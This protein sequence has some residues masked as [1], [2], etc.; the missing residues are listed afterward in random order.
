MDKE[1]ILK[2][3]K[4]QEKTAENTIR[5]FFMTFVTVL[6]LISNIPVNNLAAVENKTLSYKNEEY[7]VILTYDENAE[8]P[9]GSVLKVEEIDSE[10]D[11]YN[12]YST[13]TKDLLKWE[14]EDFKLCSFLQITIL[15][16]AGNVVIPQDK[17][18]IKLVLPEEEDD[19]EKELVIDSSNVIALN[20]DSTLINGYTADTIVSDDDDISLEFVKDSEEETSFP[21]VVLAQT[22]KE[23]VIKA[24]DDNSYIVQAVYDADSGIPLGAEMVVSEI[25]EDD[26]D[27]D[28]YVEK[29]VDK[30]CGS[31]DNV[32]L[33]KA[34]DISFIDPV[35]KNEYQPSGDVSI[36]IRL[37]NEDF[38]QYENLDVV[39]IHGE[40]NEQIDVVKSDIEED[41][42]NF[43]TDGLS[44]F[45]VFAYTTTSET[46][47]YAINLEDRTSINLSELIEE[48]NITEFTISG[49][50]D[51]SSNNEKLTVVA[52][53]EGGDW[54]ISV[55]E[56]FS[57]GTLTITLTNSSQVQI[58]V[59]NKKV[60]PVVTPPEGLDLV[61]NGDDQ[62]LINPGSASGGTMMYSLK[63]DEDYSTEIP[64]AKATGNYTVYYKIE[65]DDDYES[66][67]GSVDSVIRKRP[68]TVTAEDKTK[69][70]NS[71]DDPELSVEITGLM[72]GD[73]IV[74]DVSRVEGEDVGTYAIT[75]IGEADQGN[76]LVTFVPGSFTITAVPVTLTANSGW[77]NYDGSE[78]VLSGF[79]SSVEGLSFPNVSAE[80]RGT[81]IG[82]YDVTF[83]DVI[84]DETTDST[85]N[86]VVHETIDGELKI[87]NILSK[88][89]IDLDGNWATWLIRVNQNSLTLNNGNRITLKDTFTT[90]QSI[91]YS[92]VQVSSGVTYDY[93]GQTGT[94]SIPDETSVTISYRTRVKTVG[95]SV[96]VVDFGNTAL[97]EASGTEIDSVTT[98]ES[99]SIYPSASDVAGNTGKYMVKLYVYGDANMQA[100][101]SGAQFI[102]LDSNKRPMTFKKG[103]NAGQGVTFTTNANGWVDIELDEEEGDVS[104]EKN[105]SYSLEMIKAPDGYKLDSTLYNFMITDDPNYNSG[106]VWTYFNG[107]TI[108]VRLYAEEAGL[109][110]SLRFSGNYELSTYQQNKIVVSLERKNGSLWEQI[111]QHSYSEFVSGSITFNYGSAENPFELNETY[112]V[113]ET[114]EKPWDLSDDVIVTTTYYLIIGSEESENSRTPKEFLVDDVG[115]CINVVI[116]NEYEEPKLTITKMNKITGETLSGAVFTVKTAKDDAVVTSYTTGDD[117]LVVINSGSPYSSEILYY[118]EETAAPEHYLLPKNSIKTY[119]YFCNEPVLIP[120]ILAD[121]PEG[122][123]AVNLTEDFESLSLDNQKESLSIPVMVTWQGNRWPDNVDRV[124]I[125][126]YQSVNKTEPTPVY[127]GQGDPMKVFLT[128]TAA[129]NDSAF[130]N[131]PTRDA[132]NN[133]ITYSIKEEH[134]YK[135]DDTD[136]I[137]DYVQEYGVSD[138]GVYIVRNMQATSLTVNKYWYDYDGQPV[139][140]ES[141]LN[142]QSEVIFDVYRSTTMIPEEIREGNITHDE[143]ANFVSGLRKVRS[144]LTFGKAQNWTLTIN[145][146]EKKDNSDNPYYYYVFEN[147]PSFGDEIYVP[148]EAN[149]EISIRNTIAPE[150]VKLTVSK[151]VV[152]DPRPTAHET[153]FTFT[154]L[155]KKSENPIRNYEVSDSLTTDWNGEV[156]FKLKHD[157]SI[158]LTLPAGVTA[159]LTEAF[160]P[161]F[162]VTTE[163]VTPDLDTDNDRIFSY[164]TTAGT[165][166]NVE[167]TNTLKVICKVEYGTESV[168]VFESLKSA[169][170]FIRVNHDF[171]LD[172]ATIQM[173]EDYN[174]PSTDI[175]DVQAG[176]IITLTTA[177]TDAESFPFVTDRTENVD[178]AIITRDYSGGSLFTNAGDLTLEKVWLDGNKDFCS[179]NTDGGLINNTGTL[180][181]NSGVTL[182]NSKS[183]GKGGAIYSSG[184]LNMV[185]NTAV[186]NN[187]ASNASAIYLAA[188]TLNISGGTISNNNGAS[189]GAVVVEDASCHINLYGSPVIFNNTNTSSSAA[190]IYLGADSDNVINVISPGLEADA[191]IGVWGME[192]HREIGEQFASSEY[193]VTANLNR[194]VNDQYDYRGKL[195]EG[196]STNIIW[197]GLSLTISKVAD[198]VGSNPNDSFTITLTSTSIRKS[199]Y[200]INGSYDYTVTP[201]RTNRPGTIVF[202]NVRAGNNI[203]ISPLPVGTYT[204]SETESY[205]EPKFTAENT[206]IS[207]PVEIND[208]VFALDGN[209]TLTVTNTRRLAD[210]SLTKTLTDKLLGSAESKVFNFEVKLTE[211]DGTAVANFALGE[212]ITTGTNGVASFTM[213]PLNYGSS[214]KNFVAP[215]GAK[216]EITEVADDNY[217][218]TTSAKTKQGTDITD[219]DTEHDNIF[220]FEVTDEG[221]DVSFTNVRKLVEIE[222]SK[223]L[224][225]KV[226]NTE[227]FEFTITL[228][229]EDG[230]PASNYVLYDDEDPEKRIVTGSDGKATVNFAFGPGESSKSVELSM[231]EGTKLTVAET[232]T[233]KNINGTD[234]KIYNT[235]YSVNGGTPVSGETVTIQKVKETDTSIAFKNTRKTQTITVKN[236]VS[237]Y[238]GNVVPFTFTATVDDGGNDY[239]VHD[240]V[241]G[242]QTFELA[243][244]QSKTLTVPYGSTLKV[245]ENFVVGYDTTVKLGSETAVTTLFKEFVVS[246]NDTL[247]FNNAQLIGL[248]LKNL[249]SSALTG[250]QVYVSYGTKM[251]RVN[252]DMQG[253]TQVPLNSHWAMIDI[254]AGKTAILEVNHYNSVTDAQDYTVKGSD[255]AENYYYT[256]VN[257]PSFHEYA[258][259][260]ILR[261]YGSA[262]FEVKG[263]LR[264]SVADSTVTFTEQPLVSFDVNGGVWTTEMEGY[265]DRDGDQK[266]YQKAVDKGTT[267]SAP[268]PEPAYSAEGINFLGWTTDQAYA[269]Q[270]HSDGQVDPDKLYNFNNSVNAPV[271]LFA[272]WSRGDTR[273]VTV[274]NSLAEDITVT[275]T[276]TRDGVAIP[277]YLLFI[278]E[279][280]EYRTDENGTVTFSLPKNQLQN[281]SVPESGTKLVL[282]SSEGNCIAYSSTY[283]DADTVNSSFTINPVDSDG[284]VAFIA[285]ICK[286]TDRS[287]NILYKADG[288]PAV[289]STLAAAFTDYSGVLYTDASHTTAATQAAVKMLIDEYAISSKHTFPTKDVILTTA[290]KSDTYFPYVGVNEHST[291]YRASGFNNDSLFTYSNTATSVTLT[292]IILD[293]KNVA[294]SKTANGSLIRQNKG[295]LN[296]ETGTTLR[297]VQYNDYSDG[298]NSRGGAIYVTQGTLNVNAGS[299]Y[300]LAARRGGAICAMDKAS[301]NVSGSNGSTK[302]EKCYSQNDD[303]GAIYYSNTNE[304]ASLTINGGQDDQPGII[305]T[306]CKTNFKNTANTGNGGAIYAHTNYI[307]N[308]TISGCAFTECSARTTNTASTSGYGG[309]AISALKVKTLSVSNC[310]FSSCD[311]LCGGGAIA[312]YVKTN[313]SGITISDCSF[314]NCSCKSQGG[315]LAV[316]QDDNG[317][318]TSNTKLTIINSSFNDCSSGTNNSSGGAIQCYLP[319]MDFTSTSFAGCWAGKEGGA[320]NHYFGNNYGEEWSKSS[321]TITNCEFYRCRAEDRYDT[322]ALQHYG[323]GMNTK[324][325]TVQVTGS[326][327]EDCVSTLKEGG[328]LHLGGQG[329]NSKSTIN[330]STFKNCTAKNGGGALLSSAQTLEINNSNFYGCSSSNSNGGAVYHYRNSRA[331]S[332]QNTTTITNSTFSAVPG[333]EGED[334]V[335]CNAA[336]NGGAIWTR[337]KNVTIQKCT[338]DSCSANGNG[339]AIYLSNSSSTNAF[340]TGSSTKGT[341]TNCKA[342]NGSAVYTEYATIFKD[343][344]ITENICS[345]INDGAI[346]GGT[347]YFEGKVIVKN[348]ECSEDSQYKHDVLMQNNNST[349]IYT[350][351]TAGQTPQGLDESAS[352]GV[353]V[354]DEYFNLRGTEGKAFGTWNAGADNYLDCFFND[355]DDGLFG[356]QSSS[357]D[358]NIYWGVYLCKITDAKGNTLKRANGRD[359]IYQRLTMALDDFTSVTEG[360]PV[361][362]KILIEN[363]NIQQEAQIDNFPN[364]DIT[365]TTET[366]TGTDPVEGKYDGKHPYRGKEGTVCTISRTNSN[367][368]LF[369]LSNA[370]ATFQ[371]ENISFDGR[372]DKSSTV[373]DFR[374]IEATAGSLIINGGTTFRYGHEKLYGGAIYIS[375]P[376]A[377]LKINSSKDG[378]VLFDHCVQGNGNNR[379]NGGGAIYSKSS[380]T[381][382]NTDGGKAAFADCNAVRGGAIMLGDNTSADMFLSVTGAEFINC[383]SINEGGAVYVNNNNNTGTRTTIKDSSFENCYT[384]GNEQWSYGGAVDTKTA[385][386][387]VDGCSFKGCY[388]RSNGGAVNHGLNEVNRIKTTITN[389]SFENCSTVGT[390]S[391]Y[392]LGGSVSTYAENVEVTDSTFTNSTASSNGGALYC[393]SETAGSAIISGTSFTNCASDLTNGYGGAIYAKVKTLTL[394]N[395]E[396]G[397]ATNIKNC[398]AKGYSGAVHMATNNS[399][400]NIK[401]NTLISGCYA[402]KGAVIYLINT[403]TLKLTG[404]PEFTKNGYTSSGL[405]ST[406][407]ACIYLAEGSLID[408]SDSPK[409]SRNNITNVPRVTNGGT[410]DYVRQDLY[411]AGY[412]DIKAVSIHVSGEL[413]GD[414][415]WV[416]PEQSPHR[417]PE[418]QFATTEANV[419][420][421]SLEKFRNALDDS[422]TTCSHGEYL[423]GVRIPNKDSTGTIVY[424]D[425][426]YSLSFKKIDNK[427]VAVADAYFTLF[428]DK[429]CTQVYRSAKS[430]NGETDTDPQ[431][432]ILARGVVQ[433]NSIPIGVYYMKETVVPVGYK[434][435]DVTYIVLVGSPSLEPNDYNRDLW[436]DGGPLDVDSAPTLVAK[437]TV[438]SGKYYGIFALKTDG[439]ADLSRSIA[440]ANAGIVNTRKDY[441]AY[442][443]KTD[444]EGLPLPNTAFTL[445]T[446]VRDEHG[447][448]QYYD[449]NYPVLELWSRDGE[450]YPDPAVSAD[451]T[452]KY[453]KADGGIL[454]KGLVYFR[455][456]PVGTYYLLETAYPDRNGNNR[457]TFFVES[458]RL[459]KLVVNDNIDDFVLSEWQEDGSYIEVI[460]KDGYF[461]FSNTEAVVKLTDNN[462]VLLYTLG[463]D[464]E[465]LFPAIYSSLENGIKAAQTGSLYNSNG[466]VVAD[467]THNPALKL[468]MMKDFTIKENIIYSSERDLTLTTAERTAPSDKDRYI[469]STTRTSDTSRAEVSRG[470]NENTSDN[471]NRGALITVSGNSE[472]TLQNVNFN[473]HSSDYNGR[474][475]HVTDGSLNILNSTR[476]NSFKQEAAAGST[477]EYN[478]RGGAILMD[479]GTSLYI[480]GS[481]SN[482]SAVFT[483]NQVLNNRTGVYSAADGGA[484]A[485]GDNCTVNISNAQ[486]TGNSASSAKDGSG[487]G[488]AIKLEDTTLNMTDVVMRQ[489][490]AYEGS[491]V[492]AVNNAKVYIN[493]GSI[494]GN[495]T[496]G[497]SGGAINV[498][499][500]DSRVYFSGSPYVFE[501][502]DSTGTKQKDMVLNYDTNSII[503]TASNGLTGGT[504]G[505]YVVD[506]PDGSWFKDHGQS[507][508]PFG[509]F[510]NAQKLDVFKND[511]LLELYG[512][513]NEDDT[514]DILIYWVNIGVSVAFKKIDSFGN[515]LDGATFTLYTDR[516]CTH[517]YEKDNHQ[518]AVAISADGITT[519]NSNNDLLNKGT[520][521]FEEI[522]E[523]IYYLKERRSSS[524]GSPEGYLE[525]AKTYVVLI[526]K[527]TQ[528]PADPSGTIWARGRLLENITQAD[529]NVQIEKYNSDKAYYKLT[530]DYR[531]AIFL[532]DENSNSPTYGKAVSA[533][534]IAK[535]GVQND[536]ENK[537]K[538]ILEKTN[539]G[540]PKVPLSGAVF[541]I[542]RYDRTKIFSY[543]INNVITSS[544]TSGSNGVYFVDDLPY[545]IYYLHETG[546]PEGVTGNGSVGWWYILTVNED[547]VSC[548]GQLSAEPS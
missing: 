442:F 166:V 255:L 112:R 534:N 147:V 150:T 211:A 60:T 236:T 69:E 491:A 279:S 120:E 529:V 434:A 403:A 72:T 520:V 288:L 293:G 545:G 289:Y 125:G 422:D 220:S 188:S 246:K 435:N 157:D 304:N 281:L 441:E 230:N 231:P 55:L 206:D 97:L 499:G 381:I 393:Q 355:R 522:Y 495:T 98:D 205:Y 421:D 88:E 137:A 349:T 418:E 49:V 541:E 138:A 401:D 79:T 123:T 397:K 91:D 46:K 352:I 301:L 295:T 514:S 345:N 4:K 209:T 404:S 335:G 87:A 362:I 328:A 309:G 201:T 154:L 311:T 446:I 521:L 95:A 322:T 272:I 94:F 40:D 386:L 390:N 93:R 165:N 44:V 455:E 364:A 368:Q 266:V 132:N 305:F 472:L 186:I 213:T 452:S 462:D 109:N 173:V 330:N 317:A 23:K 377:S 149:G 339:G 535:Y 414:T 546:Y 447:E 51:V 358:H 308:V 111:E 197:D 262:A 419:S 542:L 103:D 415:I 500:V 227:P 456:L 27:Y 240:F 143:M 457:R 212:G 359:A 481:S 373:G 424:W 248:V 203:F 508:K 53:E 271:D 361:Y 244:G 89:M 214:I 243:T 128:R 185:S 251:Y 519:R 6:L 466:E 517:V 375:D 30:L 267:V 286:I 486:F 130:V 104:I 164:E 336:V 208:G 471:A 443:M 319:C 18:S 176:E 129:Y 204:I 497:A 15:D 235:T 34:F 354:P 445:Y 394:Q 9:E 14:N 158:E 218:L 177:R 410:T 106:G 290:G 367:N 77:R 190:N 343:V 260:A 140:E 425:K 29:S 416:W 506:G 485:I 370:S 378:D 22:V 392:G 433:Y 121:L 242:E 356:Y 239:N 171:F 113:V 56:S 253:Q 33:A 274:K 527:D 43:V 374:M 307:N 509:T 199:N 194:F 297:N 84:I 299:F 159:T 380:V 184:T 215:V 385:Y 10:T 179:A 398:S 153:E 458:D 116:N 399:T 482:R 222:L 383:Y 136:I 38:I 351:A 306:D 511:R 530:E 118:V 28:T 62:A 168:K 366:Y 155:L 346:H 396:S 407:G 54:T 42:V 241:N 302:F 225:N 145:D 268:D 427:A 501:N 484:I 451:G 324:A 405:N 191:L 63:Q 270:N 198:P 315:A 131:L 402:D 503:R 423:A 160:N 428:T 35:T 480:N 195:K 382:D 372:K 11:D 538:T 391:T 348:N 264:Y 278:Y 476:F 181:L 371:L 277:D 460:K 207:Q 532:I 124:E 110:V 200:T 331:D 413:T 183:S 502:Y 387:S 258:D 450:T 389:T 537:Q 303:G 544:F 75:P 483:N 32:L 148:N 409:F 146:L 31:T 142:E 17:V 510:E 74:Y 65:G 540:N 182:Q 454:P 126:L 135:T 342:V 64:S 426:M 449:N 334:K 261:I 234:Q 292:N 47:E 16:G 438:N 151:E 105:T 70:Y 67:T 429:D 108:K 543:D 196:T 175:F 494:N 437:H 24:S 92:N 187:S 282:E 412:H 489:N 291:L 523:G 117:G 477:D 66:V 78:K 473:G 127:D 12:E 316:Y 469:F 224:V 420:A 119:F 376:S 440:S 80:G 515:P 448:P 459:F 178:T 99:H 325:K 314:D 3:M 539:N 102:L 379:S 1:S 25:K 296:I 525:N 45:V 5:R 273:T 76:Y 518:Y 287:G 475:I 73:T 21:V 406:E 283:S 52:T 548:S 384:E 85:G 169:L 492:Y 61:Y 122:E 493:G 524:S 338:I 229:R 259:P 233:K 167:F 467:S 327:F 223:E 513:R 507:G 59:E 90:N 276:L 250:V 86:Y 237:G 144:N 13:K 48:L 363:Y 37:L 487:L 411:L 152:D 139:T 337:A 528:R 162:K 341:I 357:N 96:Q 298:N 81:D 256:I 269:N 444:S 496:E 432:E 344:S 353:Y 463:H 216:M 163:S 20:D 114:G 400:M 252:E 388:A 453:K 249:T 280:V 245:A 531:Y 369:K 193:E 254:E 100:G 275:A 505:I 39:H 504:I 192:S 219:L 284:T 408:L 294:L 263:K 300:N 310:S 533:P 488:G 107:D 329:S 202:N 257:E 71:G 478:V 365:L 516:D 395:S 347:L 161:E 2:M 7:E 512:V 332:T 217:R 247:N 26:E 321:V 172:G 464:G 265:R 323:G 498:G 82:N 134:V 189:N 417:L 490:S 439:K 547:G 68:V 465:S 210:V 461:T 468:K 226:L 313:E 536:P 479:N 312:A 8:I 19:E 470:Y 238:S 360:V 174:M 115:N 436:Y 285:G 318:K 221:A 333:T 36:S 232:V 83:S 320:V 170:Y 41:S 350:R 228:I 474:A 340:I 141:V 156:T 57:F 326:Y 180:N 430:A 526:G 133:Q 50:S 431:G 101:I 58:L